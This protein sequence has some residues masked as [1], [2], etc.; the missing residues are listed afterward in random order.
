MPALQPN[1]VKSVRTPNPFCI[2]RFKQDRRCTKGGWFFLGVARC[3]GSYFES[4]ENSRR[5]RVF[6]KKG[7]SVEF[8]K[9]NANQILSDHL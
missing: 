1:E 4:I 6:E 2:Q 8:G 9:R 3:S 7:I 5:C